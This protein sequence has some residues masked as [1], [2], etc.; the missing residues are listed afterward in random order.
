[1]KKF[2]LVDLFSGVGGI[3]QGFHWADFETVIANEYDSSI[4]EAYKKNFPDTNMVIGDVREVNFKEL[5]EEQNIKKGDIDVIAGGPPCQGFSMANRKRIEED[6]RNLLFLEFVRAVKTFRPK[7]FLIENVMGMTA[8]KVSIN[9]NQKTV[10]ESMT[11]YFEEIGYRIA[12]KSFKSEEHGVPQM[13]RRVI[14]IGT[15]IK[16]KF[17]DLKFLRIGNIQKEYLSKEEMK[18]INNL[19]YTL[20]D[21]IIP[22]GLKYPTTV[23]EAISDLPQFE[24]GGGDDELKYSSKPK[25]EYQ[26]L[27]REKSKKVYNH[28][29]TPHSQKVIERIKLIEQGQNFTSLPEKMKTKSVHSGAYGRLKENFLT[30][31]ITTRFDTPSTG[32]VI[33]PFSHRTLTVREAARLQSF[34]DNFK[35]VGTRTSQGKQVGNAVPPLVAKKIAEMFIKDFLT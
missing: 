12:F 32:R 4:A 29:S 10:V 5:M 18:K 1:M 27:M 9:N 17:D 16:N 14:I 13:R 30:P 15:C 31:T 34:P 6:D 21:D 33:H 24:D 19:E 2:K 7:C 22:K 20:F 11:Q 28:K 8:E 3:S 26:K 25:N 23:W 35:F